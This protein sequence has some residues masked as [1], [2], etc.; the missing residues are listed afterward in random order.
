L[1]QWLDARAILFPEGTKKLSTY[2]L[3]PPRA[4]VTFTKPDGQKVTLVLGKTVVDKKD[5]FYAK[6]LDKDTVFEV[7]KTPLEAAEKPVADLFDKQLSRFNR[8]EVSRIKIERKDGDFELAKVEKGNWEFVAPEAMKAAK[9][10]ELTRVDALLTKLQD[11]KVL[12][13]EPGKPKLAAG[14]VATTI[15]VFTKRGTEEKEAVALRFGKKTGKTVSG[16][17]TDAMAPFVLDSEHFAPFDVAASYYQGEG[18]TVGAPEKPPVAPSGEEHSADDG[19][20]HS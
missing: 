11:T 15:R 6:R 1:N 13:Y 14:A 12:R 20:G 7:D 5:K 4:R 17:R 3:E 2:G 16:D 18:K 10:L 8:F 19:H 9:K